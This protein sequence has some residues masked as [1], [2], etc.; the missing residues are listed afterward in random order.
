MEKKKT[1]DLIANLGKLVLKPLEA[2]SERSNITDASNSYAPRKYIVL[3][4]NSHLPS[5]TCFFMFG[6]AIRKQDVCKMEWKVRRSFET[7]N[8]IR[9]SQEKPLC[10]HWIDQKKASNH[11]KFIIFIGEICSNYCI[12]LFICIRQKMFDMHIRT[13]SLSCTIRAGKIFSKRP[14]GLLNILL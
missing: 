10:I 13:T 14:Y 12:F 5:S 4:T 7:I 9:F 3:L 8:I 1:S 11:N 2:L 6:Q